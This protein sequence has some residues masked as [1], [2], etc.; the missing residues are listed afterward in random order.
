MRRCSYLIEGAVVA[1]LLAA[2]AM[3]WGGVG[4]ARDPGVDRI[5]AAARTEPRGA[6]Y[7]RY[8][9][10]EIGPR[11]TGGANLARAEK[12]T[13][14]ELESMGLDV[15]AEAWGKFDPVKELGR[16]RSGSLRGARA[17]HNIVAELRGREM[18]EEFVIVGAH[19]DSWDF[20]HG[21]TDNAAGCGAVMEAA[22]ILV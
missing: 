12:W 5:I 1:A 20:A 9:A 13:R 17:V 11:L 7:A 18:P 19:L 3:A 14:K 21:A 16:N 2:A 6:E 8:L 10:G 22:R 4:T 15:K